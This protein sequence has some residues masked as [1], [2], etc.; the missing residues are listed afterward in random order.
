MIGNELLYFDP[1]FHLS[2]FARAARQVVPL[3]GH[4]N[5]FAK[6]VEVHEDRGGLG[7]PRVQDRTKLNTCI[8]ILLRMFRRTTLRSPG[9]TS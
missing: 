8:R 3:Q 1:K 4:L 9:T 7:G 2:A 6:Q 5:R